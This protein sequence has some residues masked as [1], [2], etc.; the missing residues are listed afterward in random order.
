MIEA[1]PI[2]WPLVFR[3]ISGDVAP[4]PAS[5]ADLAVSGG[6]ILDGMYADCIIRDTEPPVSDYDGKAT[7][8]KRVTDMLSMGVGRLMMPPKHT[9]TMEVKYA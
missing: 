5:L 8:K 9:N 2:G 7:V 4:P 1:G 3:A 6:L